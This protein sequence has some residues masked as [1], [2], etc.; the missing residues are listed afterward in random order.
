MNQHSYETDYSINE[1]S[2]EVI[3]RY[4]LTKV[5]GPRLKG[6]LILFSILLAILTGM[7]FFAHSPSY[8]FIFEALMSLIISLFIFLLIFLIAVIINLTKY[9]RLK[10]E[11]AQITNKTPYDK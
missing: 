4:K 6:S 8:S 2:R 5:H 7:L 3:I 10:K 11:L 9:L 1:P